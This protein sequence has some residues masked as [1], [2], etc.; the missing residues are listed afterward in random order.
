MS[1]LRIGLSKSAVRHGPE[2]L[3][4]GV[5]HGGPRRTAT[6]AGLSREALRCLSTVAFRALLAEDSSEASHNVPT[7]G[8][9][10]SWRS[11]RAHRFLRDSPNTVLALRLKHRTA[12]LSFRTWMRFRDMAGSPS[13][14]LPVVALQMMMRQEEAQR[15]TSLSDVLCGPAEWRARLNSLAF[16]GFSESDVQHWLW[17]L[18]PH[19]AD[20]QIARFVS[21]DRPKPLFLLLQLLRRDATFHKGGSLVSLYD[22]VFRHH[23]KA[24]SVSADTSRPFGSA[25]RALDPGLS[26]TPQTFTNL[27]RLLVYHYLRLWPSALP[28]VARLVS[29]YVAAI[30]AKAE[31]AQKAYADQCFVFNYALALFQRKSPISPMFQMRYNW[32]AQKVVLAMSTTMPRP[33]IIGRTG[34][35]AI[36]RV[37][38][39]LGKSPAER[40]VALRMAR[41]WPPYRRDL[42]GLDEKRQPE[43]DF[44]RSAKAGVLMREAGYA[45]Q[46][47]DRALGVLGGVLPGE[48]PTVQTRSLSPRTWTGQQ[49]NLNLFSTWAAQVKATRDVNEAWRA[50]QTAPLDGLR[51]NVQVYAEMFKKLLARPLDHPPLPSSPSASSSSSSSSTRRRLLPGDVREVFPVNDATLTAIEKQRLRPP[52][53]AAL[54]AHMLQ[55]DN[56]RPVGDC[57]SILIQH[58]PSVDAALRYLHDSPIDKNAIAALKLPRIS[59]SSFSS[60]STFTHPSSPFSSSRVRRPPRPQALTFEILRDIPLPTL[61]AYVYLMCRFQPRITV[62]PARLGKQRRTGLIHHAIELCTRRLPP[63]R[64]E[65]RTYKAPWHTIMRTLAQ[66]KVLL[67][68]QHTQDRQY[69]DT[70]ALS[71]AL[72]VFNQVT[73]SGGVDVVMFD[74]LCR[75]TQKCLRWADLPLA[76]TPLGDTVLSVG[77][78]D[79]GSA[80]QVNETGAPATTS[81]TTT[82]SETSEE[83]T[84][85]LQ[86]A[87]ATLVTAFDEMTLL[88]SAPSGGASD[89]FHHH[90][91]TPHRITAGLLQTYLQ[92]LGYLGDTG[93]MVRATQWILRMWT[94]ATV[95]EDAK[96]P[97]DGQY[98]TLC[99]VLVLVRAFVERS[100]SQ[101]GTTSMGPATNDALRQLEQQLRELQTAYGCTWRWPTAADAD[102]YVQ[103][104]QQPHT[105]AFWARVRPPSGVAAD[106][107]PAYG[108]ESLQHFSF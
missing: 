46:E 87:R 7:T 93:A 61:N 40:R 50:F 79:G 97:E 5:D 38:L 83:L 73:K 47:H 4:R 12:P 104:H 55:H 19:D 107:E 30:P 44:S 24:R 15:P 94:D 49:A 43:D 85:L 88:S 75:V 101:P 60:L 57:L 71:L 48:G 63:S 80:S 69:H 13:M 76:A 21:V 23:V 16:K 20:E 28:A 58:A 37:L 26:M 34:F 54:Y 9:R 17:I 92:T 1:A 84:R 35:R 72:S 86:K 62:E 31:N 52:T 59:A 51:P 56:C 106:T 78:P 6:P 98:P 81:A 10:R 27:L 14:R 65:G 33:L 53:V 11:R 25:R 103:W 105:E 3:N 42:D 102:A 100:T 95:L 36:R 64:E 39:A 77:T 91:A 89:H 2:K 66:P 108:D 99:R 22:Y 32:R 96:D 8:L 18:A 68:A 82:S 29:A 41:S 67:N 45:E 90:P 70:E 74:S